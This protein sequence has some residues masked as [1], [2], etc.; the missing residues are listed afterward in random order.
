MYVSTLSMFLDYKCNF[1]CDHCSVGSSPETKYEL[2]DEYIDQ[3]FEEA[4]ELDTLQ[5]V[6]FT[7]GEVTL[8]LDKLLASIKEAKSR[9]YRTRIVTNAWWAHNMERARSMIKKLVDAGLDEI[10]TS[11]DDFHTE[12]APPDNIVN[13]VEAAVE[14]DLKQTSVAMI[15]GDEN[16]TYDA[17]AMIDLLTERFG[18]HPDAYSDRLTILEDTVSPLGRGA[19]IDVTELTARNGVDSGCSDVVSTISLHPD[20][21]IK[22]CCGHAQWYVPDLTLGSLDEK[23][24]MD[25]VH[26]S[27]ENMIY[28]LIH[29][30]GPKK[31]LER[32]GV[33]GEYSGICHACHDLLGNYREEFLEYVRENKEDIVR[34]DIFLSDTIKRDAQSMVDHE[35]AIIQRL[36]NI[37]DTA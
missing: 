12:Y 23:S 24:L 35:P 33:E 32:I 2:S 13:L 8:H 27:Q 21:T 16:P 9:G 4:E 5:L 10:N 14:S 31:L 29:N 6:V 28:W 7:G 30:I 25:I 36:D 11:Y 22:A 1:A 20:G 18:A 37:A 15:I 17:Q 26:N 19:Q 34:D 3:A